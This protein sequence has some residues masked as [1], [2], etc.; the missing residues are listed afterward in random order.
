MLFPAPISYNNQVP[1][2]HPTA[3]NFLKAPL[4]GGPAKYDRAADYHY[5]VI[6]TR[7]VLDFL[8]LSAGFALSPMNPILPGLGCLWRY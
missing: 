1:K 5:T 2:E 7:D 8:L 6:G 4:R 3:K